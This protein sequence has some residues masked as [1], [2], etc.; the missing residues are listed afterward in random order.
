[1]G[2]VTENS[3][4]AVVRILCDVRPQCAADAAYLFAQTRDNDSSVI[5]VAKNIIED[6]VASRILLLSTR[7]RQG[8][9]GF[10]VW[11]AKLLE[12][13]ISE[14]LITPVEL[15]Q[16]EPHN[17]L[18]EATAL[19]RFAKQS[20]YK[21]IVVSAAP[22]H[23]VRVF[24]TAVRAASNEFP[25]LRIYNFPGIA[26]PW[27]EQ[28]VHSQGMLTATRARLIQAEFERI[29]NYY[30]KGDLISFDAALNYLDQRENLS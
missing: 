3:I 11:K 28:V 25:S 7:I 18:T 26:L 4:E 24:M 30:R 17:T 8:Y 14:T 5:A 15:N 29:N 23:Q 13:G 10:Q 2:T 22:F 19:I 16:G 20:Q 1:M 12:L 27:T 21:A 9:P 6:S